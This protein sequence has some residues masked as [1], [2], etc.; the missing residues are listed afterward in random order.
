MVA[1]R[2]ASWATK[3]CVDSL[4]TRRRGDIAHPV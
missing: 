3:I 4:R 1:T 2:I